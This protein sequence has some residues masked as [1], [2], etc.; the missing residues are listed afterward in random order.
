MFQCA[1]VSLLFYFALCVFLHSHSLPCESVGKQYL[2]EKELKVHKLKASLREI[3][4]DICCV[5]LLGYFNPFKLSASIFV[6]ALA[7]LNSIKSWVYAPI[8]PQFE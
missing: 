6:L 5:H 8:L 4:W 2:S 1:S 7:Y 3:C